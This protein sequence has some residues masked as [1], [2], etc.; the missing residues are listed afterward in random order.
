MIFVGEND[1]YIGGNDSPSF[2]ACADDRIGSECIKNRFEVSTAV[3]MMI[4]IF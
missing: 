1:I 3:T 4:I 2:D